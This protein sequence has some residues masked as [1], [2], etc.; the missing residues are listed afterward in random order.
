MALGL[1]GLIVISLALGFVQ[2]G[3]HIRL[4]THCSIAALLV[5]INGVSMQFGYVNPV[6]FTFPILLVL[7]SGFVLGVRA[8][9]FWTGA[10]VIELG[11]WISTS[12]MPTPPEGVVA[13]SPAGVF[14]SCSLIL[15][16]VAGLIA[17]ERR[18]AD[19]QSAEL[20]FLARHDPLT[21]LMNRRA[22]E[23]R[24]RE[25]IARCRRYGRRFALIALDLDGFKRVNDTYGHAAGDELLIAISSRISAMTRQT[26]AACRIGGDEFLMLLED[27]SE[28]K[29][30]MLFANRLLE[31]ICEEVAIGEFEV[32]VGASLG[33]ATFPDVA[34]DATSLIHAADLAMYAAK[35]EGGRKVCF[36]QSV[37][38][39][40]GA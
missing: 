23:L 5:G 15:L 34:A 20:E 40:V 26:D 32:S 39:G 19:R 36:R 10:C 8:A 13:I 1:M 37:E 27:I 28:D 29:N 12:P 16:G 22:I 21:G 17:L 25:S 35:E 11:L 33:L 2:N 7:V 9:A 38:E 30:V 14:L 6:G 18:F 4:I 31:R 24:L 3:R